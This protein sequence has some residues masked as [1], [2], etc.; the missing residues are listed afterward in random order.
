MTTGERRASEL[1]KV[2]QHLGLSEPSLLERAA[3]VRPAAEG[4]ANPTVT[5]RTRQGT[6]L[7]P[8][9]HT[10]HALAGFYRPYNLELARMLGDPR[11]EWNDAD[12][13]AVGKP[14]G[15]S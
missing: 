1:A 5:S 3:A 8:H 4:H 11:F 10:L 9:N 6:A 7:R 2:A 14:P 13:R 15:P 12:P